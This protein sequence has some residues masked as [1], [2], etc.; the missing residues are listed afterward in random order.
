[1]RI[2]LIAT[3]IM[4]TAAMAAV[5]CIGFTS[6]DSYS[7]PS[8]EAQSHYSKGRDL[9]A[10]GELEAALAE[11]SKAVRNDP[12]YAEAFT[13]IG[14]IHRKR[15]EYDMARV[16]YLSACR[17]DPYDYR[18]HYNL[19]VTYQALAEM[20]GG[21]Q[22]M[23]K[24]LRRAISIYIRALSLAPRSFD[25]HLNIGACYF[26][27][28]NMAMALENTRQAVRINPRSARANNNLGIIAET[29]GEN[30]MAIR[31]YK[32]S[33]EIKPNQPDILL[34]LGSV[35]MRLGRLRSAMATFKTARQATPESAAPYQ[36]IG[37]CYFRMKKLDNAVKSFQ[38]AIR[39]DKHSPGAYRGLGVVCMYKYI[40][41]RSRTDLR[42][43]AL[44][45]W[46]FSLKLQ[47]NQKDLERLINRYAAA[48]KAAGNSI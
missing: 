1:M 11:L 45:A 2:R 46:R 10:M 33:I 6:S 12:K 24:F 37:V 42:D 18:P 13:S 31:A 35:Y 41:D 38:N 40:I 48:K 21:V 27:L 17:A 9:M 19:G 26:Q 28:G 39:C 47:P 25:A 3:T 14:D 29:M 34:N 43:K 7:G 44:Q 8:S 20:A 36:Q 32:T 5:G 4:L 16:N 22:E 15:G 30:A 23:R